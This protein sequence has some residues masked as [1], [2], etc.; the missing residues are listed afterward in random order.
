MR[1]LGLVGSLELQVSFAEYRLFYRALLQKRQID[2]RSPLIVATPYYKS[3]YCD[4][5]IVHSL[6]RLRLRM[7][8]VVSSTHAKHARNVS[9]L[10]YRHG[11][12]TQ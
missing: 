7:S 9:L 2:L 5:H 6:Q 3:A 8:S 4:L 12:I 10:S 1:K 11:A